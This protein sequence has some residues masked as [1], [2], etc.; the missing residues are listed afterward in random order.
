MR[1]ITPVRTAAALAV[2][3]SLLAGRAA[4]AQPFTERYAVAGVSSD[5]PPSGIGCGSES[6]VA[7]PGVSSASCLFHGGTFFVSGRAVDG[8]VGAYTY[9]SGSDLGGPTSTTFSAQARDQ[10]NRPARNSLHI[11]RTAAR[12]RKPECPAI[13]S[14]SFA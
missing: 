9:A 3:A 7:G 14:S 5:T 13:S 12:S 11:R 1:P 8:H 4:T 6:A 2:A 10:C